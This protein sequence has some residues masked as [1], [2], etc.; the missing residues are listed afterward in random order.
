MKDMCRILSFKLCTI[1][2][3]MIIHK[4]GGRYQYFLFAPFFDP[5]EFERL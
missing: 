5:L 4:I 3:G 2:I 1:G